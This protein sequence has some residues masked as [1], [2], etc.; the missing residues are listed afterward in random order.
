MFDKKKFSNWCMLDAGD[1]LKI[2][3]WTKLWNSVKELIGILH[4][5]HILQ[6]NCSFIFSYLFLATMLI[7]WMV[8]SDEYIWR[9]RMV[10]TPRRLP[11]SKKVL[12]SKNKWGSRK[13]T[14]FKIMLLCRKFR[15]LNPHLFWLPKI[16]SWCIFLSVGVTSLFFWV[17]LSV[18]VNEIKRCKE[19][20]YLV[21]KN[22]NRHKQQIN[23]LNWID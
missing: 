18:I 9:Q 7:L 4:F 23:L 14:F 6:E 12:A 5:T 16:Y 11:P 1:A 19:P 22:F 15:T 13:E 20:F 17:D 2:K 21:I 10:V 3:S 8:N